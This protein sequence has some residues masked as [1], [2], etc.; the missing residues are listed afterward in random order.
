MTTTQD[1][2]KHDAARRAAALVESDMVLGLGSGSTAAMAVEELARRLRDGIL[3]HIIGIPT[4]ETVAREAE[5]LGIPLTT[6]EQH[7]TID[8]TIDGADEVDP[9]RRLIKGAGGALLREKI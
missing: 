7:P 5:S 9:A 4:S 2:A 8:L 1:L 3:E 6:L